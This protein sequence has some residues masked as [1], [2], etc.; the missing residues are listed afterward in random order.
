MEI[1]YIKF[2]EKIDL[3]DGFIQQNPKSRRHTIL[4]QSPHRK[5]SLLLHPKR[6]LIMRQND[7]ASQSRYKRPSPNP[8]SQLQ[9]DK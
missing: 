9:M 4:K 3:N 6:F 7:R 2:P 1:L 5:R 8:T